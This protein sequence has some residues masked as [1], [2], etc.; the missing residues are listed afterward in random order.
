MLFIVSKVF[1]YLHPNRTQ[2]LGRDGSGRVVYDWL[3]WYRSTLLDYYFG[4][5]E[6]G[7]VEVPEVQLGRSNGINII[8][9]ILHLVKVVEF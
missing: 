2:L 7:R 8:S 5:V 4:Q 6:L 1:F 3:G 9:N